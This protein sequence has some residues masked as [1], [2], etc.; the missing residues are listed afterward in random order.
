[1]LA[2]TVIGQHLE[3]KVHQGTP[4]FPTMEILD[5]VIPAGSTI[6]TLGRVRNSRSG[7]A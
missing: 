5:L 2:S 3:R 7:D 1:M 6:L 4:L